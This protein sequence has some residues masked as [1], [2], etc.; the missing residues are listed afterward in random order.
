MIQLRRH[1]IRVAL[2]AVLLFAAAACSD[3]GGKQEEAPAAGANAGQASTPEMTVQMITH[4]I[5]M[6]SSWAVARE[7]MR[8]KPNIQLAIARPRDPIA[9]SICCARWLMARHYSHTSIFLSRGFEANS[10]TVPKRR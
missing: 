9:K 4:G 7:G 5:R 3:T 1:P 10:G 2:L 6:P 8:P